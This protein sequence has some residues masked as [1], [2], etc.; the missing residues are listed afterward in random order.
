MNA[1][2][3]FLCAL[4]STLVLFG[5]ATPQGMAADPV[6]GKECRECH[7]SKLI[8]TT[9][10][11]P[12]KK[13]ECEPCHIS[14]GG[15]HQKQK[16]LFGPKAPGA[17]L[18]YQ[19]HANLA[20]QKSVHGP[21]R[22]GQCSGC[23]APHSSP[24]PHL[25][26]GEGNGFCVQCHRKTIVAVKFAHQPV[27]SGS[28]L[29]CHLP[30]QSNEPKLVKPA[31]KGICLS[32]HD[33]SLVTG[34][35]VHKPVATGQCAGCH[36]VHGGDNARLL[37][38]AS[39]APLKNAGLCYL[40]HQN[41]AQEKSVHGPI[42]QGDCGSCHL[43]HNSG[44]KKLLRG[45]GSSFCYTCHN[46][47]PFTKPF[48]HEP[49]KSGRCL[50][51]HT[52][53]QSTEANLIKPS[54]GLFCYECHDRGLASGKSVHQPVATGE[55]GSCHLIHSADDAHL[56]KPAP[57]IGGK[58]G[59]FCYNC[60]SNLAEQKTVHAPV[61][62]GKCTGC[63]LP[64]SSPAGNLLKGDGSQLCYLCHKS[65]L[66]NGWKFTHEPVAAGQCVSC[67]EPHQSSSAKLLKG[68]DLVCFECHDKKLAAGTSVHRPVATG[69]CG[70]CHA[71]HGGNN[72]K[73]LLGAFP[74][75]LH[76]PFEKDMYGFC[77]GCHD[78]NGISDRKST[79]TGFRD[80]PL[81]LHEKHVRGHSCKVCH[82]FHASDQPKLLRSRLAGPDTFV[83]TTTFTPRPDGG[84][85][86]TNCHE[87][88]TYRR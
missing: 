38:A 4:S 44:F 53:H 87:T 3:L 52:P 86:A 71:V 51:C 35:S 41:L 77:F 14:T 36:D 48:G 39:A 47:A 8:G 68:K 70:K 26:R 55:C 78:S 29:D 88:K 9:L 81:N 64:H 27:E 16:G 30:H 54:A 46:K 43:P 79:A 2:F 31:D 75:R 45:D 10:H 74:D 5:F 63:H 23:H 50:D 69:E 7:P 25:L 84:S 24:G 72:R 67:H 17:K 57:I 82:D 6:T 49:V 20:Q 28:C 85:C 33:R 73:L 56:L 66:F 42:R 13:G 62:D 76:V 58:A 40:C 12:I 21:I 11:G 19:C 65:A 59:S 34:V 61:K 60:H 22:E 1:V 37:K 32:C 15:N 83:Y 80:G 18:C